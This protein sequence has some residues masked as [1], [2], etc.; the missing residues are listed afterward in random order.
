MVEIKYYDEADLQRKIVKILNKSGF[1]FE[2]APSPYFC[3]I[4]DK[5]R[6]IYIEV[7]PENFAPAQILYGLAKEG[8]KEITYIG[9]ACSFETRF[10][11]SPS[12]ESIK[13]F[14]KK[15]DPSLSLPPSNVKKQEWHDK[16]YGLLGDHWKIYTYK[17][18]L[19][20]EEPTLE[21]FIDSDNYIYFKTL[22]EKYNINPSQF[23]TFIADIHGKNQKIIINNEGWILN[24]NTGEFFRNSDAAQL[25]VERFLG[26]HDY[27]PIRDYRD[28]TLFESVK[29][30]SNNIQ[31]ILHQID[32]LEPI[33]GRRFRGRF[34]TK[35]NIGAEVSDIAKSIDPNYILEPYVGGGTLIKT[36]IGQYKGAAND[37]NKGFIDVLKK[38]YEGYDWIFTNLN[39]IITPTEE[40]ISKWKIPREGNILI[41]TNPPFGTSST[42]SLVSKKEEIK[43]NSRSRKTKIEYGGM[44]DK[45][46]RGDQVI[47]ALGK[48]IEILKK[49]SRGYLAIF[50][51][52]GL[53]L[54]RKRYNKILKTIL[55]DFEFLEGHIFSGANFNSVASKKAI[56]FTLWKYSKN[57]NTSLV[58]LTFMYEDVSLRLKK[59]KLLKEVWRYRDG[60]KYVK[61]RIDHPLGVRRNDTFN[62]PNPKIFTIDVKEGSGAE[63]SKDNVKF[64]L[65][66]PNIPSE[67][68]YGLLSVAVGYRS[69]TDHPIFID[70]AHTHLPD[71]SKKETM[72]ILAYTLIHVLITEIKNNYCSGKIGFI[73]MNR[74][75]S[76]GNPLLTKGA[77]YLIDTYSYCPIGD[78]K[79]S[80]VFLELKTEPNIENIDENY[81]R[82]IKIEIEN[83]L[84]TIGYWDFIPI[85]SII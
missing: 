83:R 41:L 56:A 75:F 26:R 13:N 24:T 59:T 33:S 64:D 19:D 43:G 38:K 39:T 10:Y 57:I 53:L 37:I 84:K 3:D 77:K 22:F 42:S 44:G 52:A 40:L 81:R 32:R 8:I 23:L 72:E 71:F 79:I 45:Y 29:I 60:S 35:E 2:D 15:I 36:L 66:I 82:L 4:V 25:S 9:L 70:N 18:K 1:H 46:G 62:N 76:F 51:P 67:L 61:E 65:E 28:K 78:K 48:L 69:I 58:D 30:R 11:K 55:Q 21:I 47:P 5:V 73:G 54:G 34:F 27:R 49:L 85:P 14:A 80:D 6:K 50:S 16:A 7:K 12:F 63:I 68:I 74:V 20:L 31:K 17:G